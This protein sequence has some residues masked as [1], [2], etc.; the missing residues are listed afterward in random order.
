MHRASRD[1]TLIAAALPWDAPHLMMH[2]EC[3][4]LILDKAPG[5]G[6]LETSRRF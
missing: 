6:A 3:M 2:F 4:R 1:F 5:K